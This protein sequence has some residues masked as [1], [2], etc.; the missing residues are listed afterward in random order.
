MG[1]RIARRERPNRHSGNPRKACQN[2]LRGVE[3]SMIC[4]VSSAPLVCL[5]ACIFASSPSSRPIPL[6]YLRS[7]G[8][9][10]PRRGGVL[11]ARRR[12][13]PAAQAVP[14][15]DTSASPYRLV[16]SFR[17]SPSFTPLCLF[18]TCGDMSLD[19]VPSEELACCA[20]TAPPEVQRASFRVGF[21]GKEVFASAVFLPA[22]CLVS[23]ARH[24]AHALH[25]FHTRRTA[26]RQQQQ[27]SRRRLWRSTCAWGS[28]RHLNR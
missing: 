7:H 10:P 22:F 11:V 21:L 8:F 13:A 12:A 23:R 15:G 19:R 3:D 17:G 27:W 26:M 2:H 14:R 28:T 18:Y 25:V 4:G 9:S 16:L 6:R 20:P 24:C 1:H 5:E